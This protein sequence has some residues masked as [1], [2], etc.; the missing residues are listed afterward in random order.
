MKWHL[1]PLAIASIQ[2]V[3]TGL[4]GHW[5]NPSESVIIFIAR[6]GEFL[7][8]EVDWA[9]EKAMEDARKG[10]TDPLVGARLLS[11]IAPRGEDRWRARLFVPDLNKRSKVELRL[12]GL[13]QLE[14]KGCL[15]GHIVC[16]SQV[17]QR[18]VGE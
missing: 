8:G 17:W 11:D 12:S 10:G 2:P 7:C 14:V 4:E 6:C 18:V 16:K 3:E 9:S 5:R 1:L 15:V 13:D